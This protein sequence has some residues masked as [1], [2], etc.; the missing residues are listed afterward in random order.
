MFESVIFH[1]C[2]YNGTYVFGFGLTAYTG[3]KHNRFSILKEGE[4]IGSAQAYGNSGNEGL[5]TMVITP[6]KKGED[7]WVAN[8]G[9]HTTGIYNPVE[10]VN[11]FTGFRLI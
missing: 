1:R 2:P 4:V 7:V 9:G 10:G 3:S 8:T 5:S 11:H 6:C